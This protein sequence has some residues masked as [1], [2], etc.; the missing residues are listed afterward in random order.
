MFPGISLL[1]LTVVNQSYG[2]YIRRRYIKER[3]QNRL[4][5]CCHPRLHPGYFLPSWGGSS[6]ALCGWRTSMETV[7]DE[8]RE[9]VPLSAAVTINV[10]VDATWV[11]Y[12][13]YIHV[14]TSHIEDEKITGTFKVKNCR[15]AAFNIN[16]TWL[17]ARPFY[18]GIISSD[19]AS[20]KRRY[21]QN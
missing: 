21:I 15:K 5:E 16:G 14:R 6:F 1:R 17:N 11:K 4:G 10:C 9:G 20:Q 13:T 19:L 8:L 3:D 18:W 12:N 7:T 2:R